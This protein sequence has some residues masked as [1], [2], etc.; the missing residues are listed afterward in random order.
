MTTRITL[1]RHGETDWNVSG[2]WQ[3]Q[4]PVPLNDQGRRQAQLL[5]QHLLS[6]A[7]DLTAIYA[8]DLSRAYE[9]AT[10]IASAVSKSIKVDARLREINVGLWQ[11][12]TS[13]EVRAWDA[14][15]LKAV[16]LDSDTTP[17]PGGESWADVA[18]RSLEALQDYHLQHPTG[19]ILVVTHGG[20]I[21]HTLKLLKL[22]DKTPPIENTSLTRISFDPNVPAWT[23]DVF[24]LIDHLRAIDS[25]QYRE[26]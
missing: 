5:A 11:G 19:H 8:S 1:V 16:Q 10:I 17:R 6:Q 7:D 4:A 12:L 13:D 3:G 24:N 23:L 9:T 22:I 25:T 21:H 18:K 15:R 14:E 2:R 20:V 26:G